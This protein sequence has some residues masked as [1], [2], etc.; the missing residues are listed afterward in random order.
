MPEPSAPATSPA[1][2]L[3][4]AVITYVGQNY[5]VSGSLVGRQAA[6]DGFLRAYLKHGGAESYVG[7]STAVP[8]LDAFKTFVAA[9]APPCLR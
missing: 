3:A 4:Q 5:D 1:S 6:S 7:F 8:E 9:H 2:Q